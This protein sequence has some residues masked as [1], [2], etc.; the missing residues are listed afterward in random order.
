MYMELNIVNI[1]SEFINNASDDLK[2]I[3]NKVCLGVE[4]KD[5]L[6]MKEYLTLL[7]KSFRYN[8]DLG[9]RRVI[10]NRLDPN[11]YVHGQ[12]PLHFIEKPEYVNSLYI[13]KT[14]Y[15]G[16]YPEITMSNYEY[17]TGIVFL[18]HD[19]ISEI[20]ETDKINLTHL[21]SA[22]YDYSIGIIL[23]IKYPKTIYRYA[24]KNEIYH[25]DKRLNSSEL[26]KL[27]IYKNH[28]FGKEMISYE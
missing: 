9:K 14:S 21:A 19:N 17:F 10:Y 28:I 5:A 16:N 12:H 7:H 18:I 11:T 8:S 3:F 23:G 13:T 1:F 20:S 22:W 25:S 2:A 15:P 26:R 4:T 24:N 6:S 27:K